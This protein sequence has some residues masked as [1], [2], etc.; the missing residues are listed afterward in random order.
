MPVL[1]GSTSTV[2]ANTACSAPA[3]RTVAFV[4]LGCPKNLVDSEKMLGLLAESGLVPVSE[5]SEADAIVVNTCGFLQAS[6]QEAI[7]EISAA[8][9]FKKSGACKRLV[10]AGCLVQRHRAQMLNLCP[11]IDAMIGVFDR[12]CVVEAVTGVYHRNHVHDIQF[13]LN[14]KRPIY[15]SIASNAAVAKRRRHI[16]LPGYFEDDTG[17]LRLTPRHY[18]YLRVSEGCNQNC[19]FCTIPSIRG[20]MRSKPLEYVESELRELIAD[21]AYEINCIGQ[22]TTSYGMDLHDRLDLTRLLEAM[23]KTVAYQTGGSGAWIRLMYAYPSCFTDDMIDAIGRLSNVVK[24]IDLP[25]QHINDRLLTRMRRGTSRKLIESLLDKLRQRVAGVAIRTT[26]ISGFP[27]ET[28][29][30]HLELVRFV[31]D[32]GFDAM[33]VFP[34]S[35]EP[36]TPAGTWHA[37]GAEVPAAVTQRR[38]EQLMLTQQEVVFARHQRLARERATF[39]VLIDAAAGDGP[40]SEQTSV[41]TSGPAPAYAVGRAYFQAPQIDGV[42]YVD[43]SNRLVPGERVR[44]Q[45]TTASGYDLIAQP[46]AA[47]AGR[48]LSLPVTVP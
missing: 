3:I 48:G 32:F 10:V 28:E 1:S 25:L 8:A 29:A 6:K 16:S 22:D 39:D 7:N 20:K 4:S 26:F 45:I 14:A 2:A 41:I 5:Q 11:D 33:G 34:Y 30:E 46:V 21:G 15:S 19:S 18:A 13:N 40:S 37:G 35:P 43:T 42:T 24:Y 31:R 44:C 23:D 12:D 9:Q 36:G 17:R 47:Q 27:G 38:Y